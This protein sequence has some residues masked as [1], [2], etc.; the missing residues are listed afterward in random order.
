V[1]YTRCNGFRVRLV[2][3]GWIVDTRYG[4]AVFADLVEA[5]HFARTHS[6]EDYGVRRYGHMWGC[7]YYGKP[8][9]RYYGPKE[10]PDCHCVH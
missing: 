7:R 10:L 2:S 5:A 9:A 8:G 3:D 4:P 6:N 1:I